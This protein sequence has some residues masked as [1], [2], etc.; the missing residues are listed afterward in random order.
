MAIITSHKTLICTRDII[1]ALNAAAD[2]MFYVFA[3]SSLHCELE[4]MY[5]YGLKQIDF[6]L[7]LL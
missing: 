2:T 4:N 5:D 7:N 3:C 6:E 1:S